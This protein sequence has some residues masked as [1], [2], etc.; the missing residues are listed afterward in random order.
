[1]PDPNTVS[2]EAGS[3]AVLGYLTQFIGYPGDTFNCA[4]MSVPVAS[5]ESTS[6]LTL[7]Y[8]WPGADLTD[9]LAWSLQRTSSDWSSAVQIHKSVATLVQ[10]VEGGLPLSVN[11]AGTAAGRE[12]YDASPEGFSYVEATSNPADPF[13]LSFKLSDD[14]GNWSAKQ[15]L[16]GSAAEST[17]EAIAAAA[18]AVGAATAATTAAPIAVDA[19]AE[20][21]AA[22]D[23]AQQA[24]ANPSVAYDT[25]SDLN[26][27]LARSAGTVGQVLADGV[28]N[29]MYVKSGASGTG[30]WEWVSNASIPALGVA[31]GKISGLMD[32]ATETA[33]VFADSDGEIV[34]KIGLDGVLAALGLDLQNSLA[35][36]GANMSVT[37]MDDPEWLVAVADPDGAVIGGVS[38]TGTVNPDYWPIWHGISLVFAE[39][40]GDASREL[41]LTWVSNSDSARTVEY[42]AV[43]GA[44]W[45]PA[46]SFRSRAWPVT[47][48]G[49]LH[50]AVMSGLAPGV[51]YDL[52]WPGAAKTETVAT[53]P[54]EDVKVMVLSDFQTT[55]FAGL[56]MVNFGA[57]CGTEKP[58]LLILNGDLV[59]DD[60]QFTEAYAGR[61]YSFMSAVSQYYRRDGALIPMAATIGNHEGRNAAD[62]HNA[63]SGGT[64]TPGMIKDIMS[65]G[66]DM[67]SPHTGFRSAYWFGVGRELLVITLET[68]HTVPLPS[69]IDWFEDVLAV[70]A[71]NYRHILVAGHCTAFQAADDAIDWG[72]PTVDTQSRALRRLF[73]PAMQPYAAKIRAYVAGHEHIFSVTDRLRV[74]WDGDL[75]AASNDL[76]WEVDAIHGVRQI[77]A[78]PWAGV[79]SALNIEAAQEESSLDGS[80]RLLAALGRDPA[81]PTAYVAHGEVGNATADFYNVWMLAFDADG[82]DGRAL[83]R[84][85][86]ALYTIEEA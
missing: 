86:G 3:T 36:V 12:L 55:A 65:C 79:L 37:A 45:Q 58:H 43:G 72:W 27:D 9:S 51:T 33:A 50:T 74:D 75:P 63:E 34:A 16:K 13:L 17:A 64:G 14:T 41:A 10:R 71:G 81:N 78:G 26:A 77:G 7:E 70:Q 83:L 20:A 68:D 31:V 21:V 15:P 23:A 39:P 85:G 54:R 76:R 80:P 73:W 52:R 28:N 6:E 46:V 18:E 8:P 25:L 69:Q 30:V 56:S 62:N 22:R 38:K 4:G 19:A 61:W 47:G 5:V 42:R 44:T 11:A 84:N 48:D 35:L 24:V 57:V 1:M 59:A 29:G 53:A 67:D 82:F 49:Y 60:G 2:V 66:F 32:V 40:W